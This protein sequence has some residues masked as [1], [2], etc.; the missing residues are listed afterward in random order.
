[1]SVLYLC[2]AGNSECVRL[3]NRINEAE[4][5]WERIVL[6]DD[7][8]ARHGQSLLGVCIEGPFDRL[9]RAD[10]AEARIAN[11]VARST[12]RRWQAREKMN[13]FGIPFAPLIHPGVDMAGVHCG[14]DVIL[15][16]NASVGPEV[17]MGEGSVVFI[18]AAVGHEAHMGR[19]CVLAPNAVINARVRLG[20]GVYVGTCAAI[21]P[22][23]SVGP[24][25]T[26]GAGSVVMRD[27][28]AGA[29]V[30]GVPA[31]TVLTLEQKLK[32]PGSGF[33]RE[34]MQPKTSCQV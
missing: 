11:V 19:C 27:V 12:T 30:I 29:T 24:W 32:M 22:E 23:V 5:R 28:P 20:D 15:Y 13:R 10:P 18:G 6:L 7:D 33:L 17:T 31:K 9:E 3:A 1:M 14:A 4:A 21:L 2:G 26:I 25:A 16:H 34:V 8:P